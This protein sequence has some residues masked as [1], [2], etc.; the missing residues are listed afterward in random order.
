MYHKLIPRV[1]P[2]L[3]SLIGCYMISF[4]GHHKQFNKT[5]GIACSPAYQDDKLYQPTQGY[6]LR[7]ITFYK[8]FTYNETLNLVG[9]GTT[10]FAEIK[11]GE[12]LMEE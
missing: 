3:E 8:P 6:D 12:N 11:K 9:H 2:D 4:L 5:V 10:K 1:F 7:F